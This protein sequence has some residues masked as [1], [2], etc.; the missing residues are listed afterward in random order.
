[1]GRSMKRYPAVFPARQPELRTVKT[2]GTPSVFRQRAGGF[3]A[4]IICK[5]ASVALIGHGRYLNVLMVEFRLDLTA[6]G[7]CLC[8]A[9][10]SVLQTA[11]A[12]AVYFALMK[13]PLKRRP[14]CLSFV[15]LPVV[16]PVMPFI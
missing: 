8:S 11:V 5:G 4:F 14:L 15:C 13:M 9:A 12:A 16:L 2:C 6:P 3:I 1:M 7:L 10:V